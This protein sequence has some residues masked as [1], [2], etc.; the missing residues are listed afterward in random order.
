[1]MML[2]I[3]IAIAAGCASGLMFASIIS[4]ALVSLVLF[5]LAPLPLMV[6]A[7]GW[8][9]ASALIGAV[10]A[11]AGPKLAANW[12]TG[13]LAAALN[14]DDLAIDA[15]RVAPASLAALLRRIAD[16]T[17]SGKIAKDVFDA[18]WAGE[19]E[20]DAIIDRKGLRQISD[21]GA[22]EKLV[23]DVLAGNPAIVA[24]YRAGKDKLLGFF[25]GQVMKATQGKANPGLVNELLKKKLTP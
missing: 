13:E 3:L 12:I 8:G 1:M 4:G 11:G 24:E 19:G 9:P 22:I 15:A 10:A 21:E 7:L 20:P 17:I 2:N 16:G 23:D 14:R 5:Y 25:V 6:A 18:M